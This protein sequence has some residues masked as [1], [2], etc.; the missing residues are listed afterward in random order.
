MKTINRAA[1]IL[2]TFDVNRENIALRMSDGAQFLQYLPR[3]P[4]G[5][6]PDTTRVDFHHEPKVRGA[7][8]VQEIVGI[9]RNARFNCGILPQ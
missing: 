4:A 1:V 6:E 3:L 5:A 8:T 2:E 9:W 7:K